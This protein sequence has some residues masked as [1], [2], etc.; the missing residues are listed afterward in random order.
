MASYYADKKPGATELLEGGLYAVQEDNFFHRVKI[1]SVPDRG[2]HLFFRV[3]VRF[4]DTGKEEEVKSSQILQLPEQFHSLSCQAVEIIVCRV[5][6]VDSE[7]DWH[8]KVLPITSLC[9]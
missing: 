6:P 3:L 7:I 1:L 4:I 8:P 2:D 9:S 5:K